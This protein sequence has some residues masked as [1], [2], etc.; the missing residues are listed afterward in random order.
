MVGYLKKPITIRTNRD[1]AQWKPFGNGSSHCPFCEHTSIDLASLR[2]MLS[3]SDFGP[4]AFPRLCVCESGHIFRNIYDFSDDDED[5]DEEEL[6]SRKGHAASDDEGGEEDAATR[7]PSRATSVAR[8]E[9]EEDEDDEED[10]AA[11]LQDANALLSP[12]EEEATPK[13]STTGVKRKE[14]AD[15]LQAR[16]PNKRESKK[17]RIR[18]PAVSR[19][20]QPLT[21]MHGGGKRVRKPV[22]EASPSP[23]RKKLK[24]VTNGVPV[25]ARGKARPTRTVSGR[26]RRD[27]TSDELDLI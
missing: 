7:L 21:P 18:S 24:E 20:K 8:S 2:K 9:Q 25:A 13:P 15:A 4:D 22:P 17:P 12:S 26:S 16:T 3:T 5:E 27:E 6:P 10:V 1:P 11:L 14:R 19:T 23:P